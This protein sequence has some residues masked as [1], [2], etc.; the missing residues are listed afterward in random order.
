MTVKELNEKFELDYLPKI[1]E[2]FP[3]YQVSVAPFRQ[4]PLQDVVAANVIMDRGNDMFG[5]I[6]MITGTEDYQNYGHPD[7]LFNILKNR[8]EETICTLRDYDEHN[9]I[10]EH[11]IAGSES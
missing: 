11:P 2:A 7:R 5:H 4:R 3:N 8:T 1:K 6:I 10:S 9:P